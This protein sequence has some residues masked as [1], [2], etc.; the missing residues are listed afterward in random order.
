[1]LTVVSPR[2]HLAPVLAVKAAED[3]VVTPDYVLSGAE[4]GEMEINL[5]TKILLTRPRPCG[6]V[7]AAGQVE[8]LERLKEAGV[9]LVAVLGL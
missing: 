5:L 7:A 6:A 8:V 2:Q 4:V 1:M 3:G 9:A